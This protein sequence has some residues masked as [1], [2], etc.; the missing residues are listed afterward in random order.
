MNP[1]LPKVYTI[2]PERPFLVTLAAGL[3]A[4]TAGDPLRLTRVTVLLPTRRAV[5]SLREAFLRTT[6]E[7]GDA[8]APLLLPRMWPIGD[9]DS[10]ELWLAEGAVGGHD[11]AVPPAIP[12]LRRRLLLTRLVL[13]WGERRGEAPITPGQAAAVLLVTPSPTPGCLPSVA[14]SRSHRRSER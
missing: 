12:E 6:P 13:S 8:G 14:F 7:G 11:L 2:T 5:R 1:P 10:D 3:L 9:L 4:M